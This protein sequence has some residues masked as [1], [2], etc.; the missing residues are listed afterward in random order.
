M[1]SEWWSTSSAADLGWGP[2]ERA[3][4]SA[5][6]DIPGAR[7]DTL[8]AVERKFCSAGLRDA[9][10]FVRW[11]LNT[12]ANKMEAGPSSRDVVFSWD[13]LPVEAM[14][15]AY[16]LR[17]DI[18]VVLSVEPLFYPW[19][20][21]WNDPDLCSRDAEAPPQHGDTL[22][23]FIRDAYCLRQLLRRKRDM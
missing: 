20:L 13:E 18:S 6:I 3:T 2:I 23:I 5:P 9:E 8:D 4:A 15:S 12:L 11:L 1:D 10:I 14:R 7:D 22:K 16:V 19:L 21:E 17:K